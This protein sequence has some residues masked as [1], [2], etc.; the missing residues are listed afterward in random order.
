MQLILNHI[1][2]QHGT[3]IPGSD[4][5]GFPMDISRLV[6]CNSSNDSYT[7]PGQC[8]DEIFSFFEEY[9]WRGFLDLFENITNVTDSFLINETEFLNQISVLPRQELL[10]DLPMYYVGT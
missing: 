10:F 4:A 8:R 2:K 9:D 6:V 3:A 5:Y 1:L 7:N